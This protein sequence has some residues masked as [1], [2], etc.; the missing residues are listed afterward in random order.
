MSRKIYWQGHA[1]LMNLQAK[2]LMLALCAMLGWHASA[3]ASDRPNILLVIIDTLRADRLE[4]QRGGLLVM[5]NLK[6]LAD[7]AVSFTQAY[8]QETFTK[9]S[10]TS[11][12]TSLYPDVHGVRLGIIDPERQLP[13]SMRSKME[14][15]VD[16]LSPDLP[17][18]AKILKGTGYTT[19][20]VQANPQLAPECGFSEG[21]DEYLCL[22]NAKADVVLEKALSM[23]ES[24]STPCF[25]YVHF[26]DPHMPYSPP[27][28]FVKRFGPAPQ[29]TDQDR[30]LFQ[31]YRAYYIDLILH[32]TALNKT[33][34]FG[35]FSTSGRE[36]V[37]F[38][39][40]AEVNFADEQLPVLLSALRKKGGSNIMVVTS[41]HGEE[42]WEHGSVGHV[43]TAYREL[44]HV[45]L[46][47][48]SEKWQA[49]RVDIPVE[50]IDILPTIAAYLGLPENKNWQ[51][52][53][54]LPALE[55][56]SLEPRPVFTVAGGIQAW[57]PIKWEAVL[58]GES[59]FVL[60]RIDGQG[61]LYH[62]QEDPY[63][64]RNRF[65]EAPEQV[66]Q[67]QALLDDHQHR[68]LRHPCRQTDVDTVPLP[69]E[70]ADALEA[71]GYLF[72]GQR[73]MDMT[74]TP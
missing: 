72:S 58:L 37:R 31:L 57:W 41:D 55:G 34:D 25:L 52:R 35:T 40:D 62:Y 26:M 28:Q 27:G 51:G 67:L 4:A 20:A 60:N 6:G 54:L 9:P 7:G 12:M 45:P 48:I 50:T 42:F 43:K 21:F 5:P 22:F 16:V 14:I 29:I 15:S 38:M 11:I 32:G 30:W 63:E 24:L 39:Y 13:E 69:D 64:Q 44:A 36:Y 18:L 53:N 33:R 56:S 23:L 10:V 74:D 3:A 1:T 46:V 66:S 49:Q 73:P 8:A 70:V 59:R 17:T 61:E 19:G 65:Q 71:M 2:V 47:F 68:N